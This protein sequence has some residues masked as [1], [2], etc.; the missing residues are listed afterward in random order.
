[1]SASPTPKLASDPLSERRLVSQSVPHVQVP[2]S[3]WS[4]DLYAYTKLATEVWR[5]APCYYC[6]AVG[7]STNETTTGKT[8]C[9][10]FRGIEDRSKHGVSSILRT[11]VGKTISCP[12]F[13]RLRPNTADFIHLQNL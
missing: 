5:R 3:N 7:R 11:R 1:M 8:I 13:L 9:L 12:A 10:N 6:T 2:F 4:D